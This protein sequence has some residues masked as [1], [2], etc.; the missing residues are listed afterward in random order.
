[1]LFWE[2]LENTKKYKEI[3]GFSLLGELVKKY[4]SYFKLSKEL[5]APESSTVKS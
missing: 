4:Q 2:S 1:M 3:H 5:I